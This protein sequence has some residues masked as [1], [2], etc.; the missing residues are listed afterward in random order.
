VSFIF[1]NDAK[2]LLI[3]D[4]DTKFPNEFDELFAPQNTK[5]KKLPYRAPNL[6]PYAEGWVGTIKRECLDHFFVFGEGHFKYL[7][8]EYVDY[9]DTKRPHSGINNEPLEY[10]PQKNNGRIKCESR[11]GGMIKHYYLG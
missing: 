11:L 9:Y 4:G 2:K 10:K 3:R 1:Q 7:I 6:N 8:R 5:V